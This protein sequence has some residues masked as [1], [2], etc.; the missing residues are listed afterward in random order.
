MSPA[1]RRSRP[2]VAWFCGAA[3]W[4]TATISGCARPD[5][6]I[7]SDARAQL[8]ADASLQGASVTVVV[9]K[10]VVLLR[11]QV[12]SPDQP[13]DAIALVARVD[14]VRTVIDQLTLSDTGIREAL[15]HA[16]GQDPLLTGVPIEVTV[17]DGVVTLTSSATGADHRTRAVAISRAVPGVVGVQ[18][19]MK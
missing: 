15:A 8:A 1:F 2:F 9:K 11:G 14:G 17:V 6:Q 16:F 12:P 7:A 4:C 19:Q 13:R 3:L 5:D 10:G 18:D